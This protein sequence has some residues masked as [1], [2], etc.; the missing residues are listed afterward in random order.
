MGSYDEM[1]GNNDEVVNFQVDVQNIYQEVFHYRF[2]FILSIGYF[3]YNATATKSVVK[4]LLVDILNI[5]LEVDN[6]IIVSFHFIITAHRISFYFIPFLCRCNKFSLLKRFIYVKE[7]SGIGSSLHFMDQI[8][9]IYFY[10]LMS[11]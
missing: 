1:K 4:N 10:V 8:F 9:I 3:F 5:Y 11:T 7:V 2:H 6:F